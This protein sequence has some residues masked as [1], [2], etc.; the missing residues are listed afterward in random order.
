MDYASDTKLQKQL[1][2]K[3]E[4]LDEGFDAKDFINY[5]ADK[6]EDGNY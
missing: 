4:I 2:L 6:K 1:F 3:Q 5:I